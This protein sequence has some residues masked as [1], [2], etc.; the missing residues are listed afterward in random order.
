MSHVP[1]VNESRHKGNGVTLWIGHVIN[2]YVISHVPRS[3]VTHRMKNV[4]DVSV[5]V[6]EACPTCERVMS[7]INEAW[8]T[9]KGVM[10][11]MSDRRH[12]RYDMYE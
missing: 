3:H 1:H 4:T 12:G 5:D 2:E 9:Y 10:S 8:H 6:N 7:Y 11:H